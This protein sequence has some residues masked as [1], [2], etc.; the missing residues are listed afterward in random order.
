M[1][2]KERPVRSH[3]PAQGDAGKQVCIYK[4]GGDGVGKRSTLKA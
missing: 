1:K 4:V 3:D 2:G